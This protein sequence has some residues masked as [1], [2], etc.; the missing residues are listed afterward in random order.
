MLQ[1]AK[2]VNVFIFYIIIYLEE[3]QLNIKTK[4]KA[5]ATKAA[6]AQPSDREE[7]RRAPEAASGDKKGDAGAG[8]YE[9][10]SFKLLG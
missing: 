4:L 7:Y 3:H 2:K 1:G 8:S 6:D 5:E 10:V 9:F